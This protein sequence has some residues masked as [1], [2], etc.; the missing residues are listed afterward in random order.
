VSHDLA[1]GE[2]IGLCENIALTSVVL[3]ATDLLDRQLSRKIHLLSGG[4]LHFAR[5]SLP[6]QLSDLLRLKEGAEEKESVQPLL[7]Q[8]RIRPEF[9]LLDRPAVLQKFFLYCDCFSLAAS[10]DY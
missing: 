1:V 5:C 2:S 3:Q 7:V 10:S 4:A 6:T 8:R 9:A